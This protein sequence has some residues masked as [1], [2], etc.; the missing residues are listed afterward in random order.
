M[1]SVSAPYLYSKIA[2]LRLGNV[3]SALDEIDDITDGML[4][5]GLSIDRANSIISFYKASLL[6]SITSAIALASDESL[7]YALSGATESGSKNSLL[8]PII[9]ATVVNPAELD[10]EAEIAAMILDGSNTL[11]N[12]TQLIDRATQLLT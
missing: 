6:N 9:A 4:T 5:S 12:L 3:S 2:M 10:N 11:N 7:V 1:S 8:T